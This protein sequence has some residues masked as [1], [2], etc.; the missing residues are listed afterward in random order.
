MSMRS[1]GYVRRASMRTSTMR[2][3]HR[4]SSS[5]RFH[6]FLTQPG[7]FLAAMRMK[8]DRQRQPPSRQDRGNNVMTTSVCSH[9]SHY[10]RLK[11]ATRC[12]R[13]SYQRILGGAVTKENEFPWQCALLNSDGSFFGCSA[14]L[15]SCD[16]VILVT[17]AHCFVQ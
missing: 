14:V 3:R 17:A 7:T 10:S 5:V 12:G 15:L 8:L 4:D 2:I 16:P 11:N 1:V 13:K 9:Y 6:R